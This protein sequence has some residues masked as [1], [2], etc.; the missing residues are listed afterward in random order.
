[1]EIEFRGTGGMIR[2]TE[3]IVRWKVS[4]LFD[5]ELWDPGRVDEI[6]EVWIPELANR[7]SELA[8]EFEPHR[9]FALAVRGIMKLE[10]PGEVGLQDLRVVDAVQQSS[11]EK[12]AISIGRE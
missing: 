10:V 12:R 9:R 11:R 1:D 6:H 7:K 4:R 3:D 2:R 8:L 5:G